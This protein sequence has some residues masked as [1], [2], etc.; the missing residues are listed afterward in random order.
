MNI[1]ELL[2]NLIREKNIAIENLTREQVAE[3][4][5]QAILCGDFTRFVQADSNAQQVVYIPY[6]REQE[7][8]NEIKDLKIALDESVKLQ[9]HYA[10]LLNMWEMAY[11]CNLIIVKNGWID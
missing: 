10:S 3:A 8:L 9:S 7:L 1:N 2:E 11:K 4:L 6:K 5:K